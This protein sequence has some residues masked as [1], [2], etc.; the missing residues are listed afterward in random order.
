MEGC[1]LLL[2]RTRYGE[3]SLSFEESRVCVHEFLR[4]KKKKILCQLCDRNAFQTPFLF[5]SCL[6]RPQ[7]SHSALFSLAISTSI[8]RG[9]PRIFGI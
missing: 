9:L 4:L 6:L 8:L 2:G 7:S 1:L 3:L 5:P